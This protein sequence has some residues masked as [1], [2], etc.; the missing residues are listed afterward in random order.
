MKVKVIKCSSNHYWY[1]DRI[2]EVFDVE[3]CNF[4]KN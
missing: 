4:S 3:Q 2:G 1:A